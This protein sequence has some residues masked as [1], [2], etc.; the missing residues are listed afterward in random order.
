MR[1]IYKLLLLVFLL[2]FVIIFSIPR[3]ITPESGLA[4]SEWGHLFSYFF[5]LNDFEVNIDKSIEK[6]DIKIMWDNHVIYDKGRIHPIPRKL[7]YQYRSVVFDVFYKDEPIYQY[8]FHKCNNWYFYKHVFNIKK[9][10][11]EVEVEVKIT[12]ST[13]TEESGHKIPKEEAQE[14]EI[15]PIE[16]IESTKN[17]LTY[18]NDEY[19]FEFKHPKNF[20][21]NAK[22]K[23]IRFEGKTECPEEAVYCF[24]SSVIIDVLSNTK[25]QTIEDWFNETYDLNG[26]DLPEWDKTGEVKIDDKLTIS[27]FPYATEPYA[28]LYVLGDEEYIYKIMIGGGVKEDTKYTILSTFKFGIPNPDD[29]WHEIDIKALGKDITKIDGGAYLRSPIADVLNLKSYESI[30]K[31]ISDTSEIEEWNTEYYNRKYYIYVPNEIIKEGKYEN[32]YLSV[33]IKKV[34]KAIIPYFSDN[35]YCNTDYDCMIRPAQHCKYGAFN[36][37]ESIRDAPYGCVEGT[38]YEGESEYSYVPHEEVLFENP[39]CYQNKCET[40]QKENGVKITINDLD[41]DNKD[42]FT[43]NLIFEIAKIKSWRYICEIVEDKAILESNTSIKYSNKEKGISMMLPYNEEW[44][45]LGLQVSPFDEIDDTVYYD[46]Y[47]MFTSV[48]GYGR[49]EGFNFKDKENIDTVLEKLNN[50]EYKYIEPQIKEINGLQV[51]EYGAGEYCS[52]IWGAIVFTPDYNIEFIATCGDENR[53]KKIEEII[54]TIKFN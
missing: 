47:T 13:A 33:N 7:Y 39:I 53:L 24:S 43:S 51:V 4:E 52:G 1:K 27:A 15:Q 28:T 17:W 45:I 29:V 36:N 12:G 23:Q 44:K 46:Q 31:I 26:L 35:K 6:E 49:M 14:V 50:Q 21:L 20:K 18:R 10:D 19:H 34:D 32:E 38:L 30:E 3:L 11:S 48:C 54:K 41:L 8:S 2:L 42:F 37:F 22:S 40:K 25:R 16:P 5:N 9:I